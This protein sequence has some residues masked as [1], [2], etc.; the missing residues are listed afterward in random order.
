VVRLIEERIHHP[1]FKEFD[2]GCLEVIV[3]ADLAGDTPPVV[4]RIEEFTVLW[5]YI[6]RVVIRATL[7]RNKKQVKCLLR[8]LAKS[9]IPLRENLRLQNLACIVIEVVTIWNLR[10]TCPTAARLKL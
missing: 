9:Y 10:A 7:I 5:V 3:D 4:F 1:E 8:S 2:I 6:G